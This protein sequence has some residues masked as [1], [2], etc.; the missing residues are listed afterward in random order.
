MGRE[1]D[2]RTAHLGDVPLI[3][4]LNICCPPLGDMSHPQNFPV[5]LKLLDLVSLSY[6][7]KSLALA[8]TQGKSPT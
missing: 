8:F 2:M 5:G 4:G 3:F 6:Y 1:R 7:P